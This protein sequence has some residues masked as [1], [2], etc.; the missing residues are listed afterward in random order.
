MPAGESAI[1]AVALAVPSSTGQIPP[2][3]VLL[4]L[5]L[6]AATTGTPDGL[7]PTAPSSSSAVTRDEPRLAQL[8]SSAAGIFLRLVNEQL[9]GRIDP[10]SVTFV[11][12]AGVLLEDAV[13]TGPG[14]KPVA[15]VK[16][17]LVQLSVRA[18]F[19]G[20]ILISRIDIDEPRLLLEL[21]D[22]RLNLLEAL[23]P[24][25]PPDPNAKGAEGSFRI[26][27]IHVTN[28]GFRFN[29]GE[30]V[31][32]V[33]DD[34]EGHAS[35]DVNLGAKNVVVD[36]KNVSV[37]TGSVRLQ[38]LDIPLRGLSAERIRIVTDAIEVNNVRATALGQPGGK[39]A[40]LVV[41][42]G[43]DVSGDGALRLTGTVD[44]DADAWPE[45]LD[46]LPFVTPSIKGTVRVTGPFKAPVVEVDAALGSTTIVGYGV[47]SGVANVRITAKD[48]IIKEGSTLRTGKG[49]ARVAGVVTFP[50]DAVA[51]AILDLRTRITHLPLGVALGPAE[52]D[53]PMRG[54]LGG[55]LHI[56]G[57]AGK[58][59]EVLI[60]GDV[61]GHGVQIYDLVLPGTMA[62]DVRL[63]ATSDKVSI[64]R[65]TLKEAGDGTRVSISGVVDL[66]A[67]TTALQFE[68]TIANPSTLVT[69]LPADVKL[70]RIEG[71]GTIVGPFK[72]TIVD[73]NA[74]IPDGSAYGTP[75]SAISA[76]VRASATE[77]CIDGGTGRVADGVLTQPAPLVMLLGK[78]TTTFQRG[79]FHVEKFDVG[80]IKTPAGEPLPV[81]GIG[82][83]EADLRGTTDKPRVGVRVAGARVMVADEMLGDVT[84]ALVVTKDAVTFKSLT[85]RSPLMRASS[86][87]LRIATDDLRLS[88]TIAVVDLD[89]AAVAAASSARLKGR[90]RGSVVLSGLATRPTVEGDL[91]VRGLSLGGVGFG[92]GPVTVGVQPDLQGPTD[93]LAVT[94]AAMTTWQ[95]GTWR[96]RLSYA[97]DRDA[98]AAEVV[99]LDV[100]LSVLDPWMTDV[101]VPLQ[102]SV[103]GVI[104]L[105]GPLARPSGSFKLRIPELTATLDAAQAASA[106]STSATTTST[107]TRT[108]TTTTTTTTGG[109]KSTAGG[110]SEPVV[111][112]SLGSVFLGGNLDNGTLRGQVCAFPDTAATGGEDLESPCDGPQRVWASTS[113]TLNLRDIAAHVLIDASIA[114]PQLQELLPALASRDIAVGVRVRLAASIDVPET[115]DTVVALSSRLSELNLRVPGAPAIRLVSPVDLDY[116]GGRAVVGS[117]SARF[118]TAREGFDLVIAAG[119]SVG[120]E[121]VDISIDGAVALAALKLFT[122]EIANASGTAIAHLKATG[123]FDD[124]VLIEGIIEPQPGAQIMPR[125]LGQAVVFEAAR[126]ALVPDRT[127]PR[128]LRVVFDAP[129]GDDRSELCPLRASIGNGRVQLRG[130]VLAKTSREENETWIDTFNLAASATGVEV[131]TSLGRVETSFDV[132][133]TGNAPAPILKGRLDISDGLFR[134]DFQVR[135]F[136]LTQ[137]P[138]RPSAPLWQT[139][140]PFGLGELT[141]DVQ[142]T[143]QNVRTKARINAFSVDASVRG[144]LRLSRSIKFPGIDGAIEVE[145]GTVD[146]PRARFD[147]L[148]L[149]VQFPTA[150]EGTIKPVLHLAARA[151]LPPGSAGNSVEVPVDLTIDGSFEA[152]QLDLS[153]SDPARLW[154]RSEL[155]AHILFG[156]VPTSESGASLVSTSVDVASRA[157]LRELA[158]PVN[159]EVES[160]VESGLGVDVNIDVVSGFQLQLGRRLVLEGPG[161][162]SQALATSDSTTSVATTGTSGTDAL[163]VRLLFYDHLPLGR[164]LSA[165]GRFG[166]V[167]DLRLSWRLYE[168]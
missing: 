96:A 8:A 20:D 57:R 121:D 110:D 162:F 46:S 143:M 80:R 116:V 141:F 106:A 137:A 94:L 31:T 56:T 150:A 112:R 99:L 151:E 55:A 128:R 49:T 136:I 107:T 29:D 165:E 105:S 65:I 11:A 98:V 97:L 6:V 5:A 73:V 130:D 38:P 2:V 67:E 22:G 69:M 40:R 159:R 36:V 92:D 154:T 53:T 71:T 54:T 113:G 42:G 59:T 43:L 1:G 39:S 88:G 126:I 34:I 127:D 114:E 104:A 140:A 7:S 164:A 35:V 160:L 149:Q 123:R 93:S 84:A 103:N 142:A 147:I 158:A 17:A 135:N 163:R 63:T 70:S 157:A 33:F 64:A 72:T 66:K 124:G 146:F 58:A 16:R 13:L 23:T 90:A 122:D 109:G 120:S 102:G 85:A 156:V 44:A 125:S 131:K 129:C 78:S 45:R 41:N 47:D 161:L 83:V 4:L 119:S 91:F 148:E 117:E 79:T 134:K 10:R 89:L 75:F 51:D 12:P 77:V 100:D 14:G 108:T 28:G 133:L 30:N 167:S 48:V 168:D 82:T 145:S 95:R 18:L 50:T 152:M 101:V 21:E 3:R 68:A 32:L 132:S 61:Q 118:V 27:D 76:K 87:S 144:D 37:A 19:S 139:L 60:A 138:E 166:L 62:G 24:R 115:G 26:D 15:R 74:R 155:F 153:A 111:L 52:L 9:K 81:T 86:D 25:T